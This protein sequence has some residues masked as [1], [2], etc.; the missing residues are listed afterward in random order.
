MTRYE[1]LR[2]RL[3]YGVWRCADGREVLFNRRYNPI[4]QRHANG[5][6]MLA[7]PYEMVPFVDQE[8]FF[9]DSNPPWDCP[10]TLRRCHAVLRAWK[11]PI[12]VA[13]DPAAGTRSHYGRRRAA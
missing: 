2:W 11:L 9:R 13:P 5:L 7:D 4:W 1:E 12:D 3:P 10:E 8:W 6:A